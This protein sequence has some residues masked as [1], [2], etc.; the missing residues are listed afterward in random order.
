LRKPYPLPF[1]GG[2]AELGFRVSTGS[3]AATDDEII[4]DRMLRE[5]TQEYADLLREVSTR[6]HHV[7]GTAPDSH[8]TSSSPAHFGGTPSSTIP[9][10]ART[11][12]THANTT[13]ELLLEREPAAGIAAATAAV[14]DLL[15][16]LNI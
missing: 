9:S 3:A 7:G 1:S 8:K 13:L 5:L 4:A 14:V 2:G 15:T 6:T 12:Q 16:F 11:Q 10:E